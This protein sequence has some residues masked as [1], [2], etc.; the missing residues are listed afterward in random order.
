ME[1]Q[2][3]SKEK[4]RAHDWWAEFCQDSAVHGM[5]YLARRDLHWVERLFWLAMI[6]A[7][8]YYAISSCYSQWERFRNNPIVYE[9]EYLFALRNFTF[10]G[11]TFCTTYETE[12]QVAKLI[13]D[14]WAVDPTQDPAKAA[15]YKEFLY[16]LNRLRYNNLET[17]KPFEN[18]T[19]LSNLAYVDML[20]A[21]QEKV[22]PSPRPVL[23]APIITEVGLCQS[24]SQLTRYGNPYG[25]LETLNVTPVRQ[26]GFFNECQFMHKPFNSIQTHVF[27]YMH[28]VNE[29]M[30]P[31]DRRTITFDAKTKS[32]YVLKLL[33]SSISADREVRNLP[34]AY[35]KCRYHD[36]NNLRYYSPYHPS[37]CRLECR[38]NWA[39]SMCHCKPF[40]Y[41]A[42][43]QAPICNV[44]GM[45]CL[46]ESNWLER[47][48]HCF[49]LCRETTY[50]I[51]EEYEQS[52]GDQS[53]VGEQFERTIIIKLE[54]PKMGM[55]RRVVFSTD[56]LI[57]S[58]GGAIGLFLGASFMTFYGLIHLFLHFL[59][60]QCK[61]RPRIPQDRAPDGKRKWFTYR[62]P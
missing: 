25:R 17:L 4:C 5:P 57:M 21:L 8:A 16:V 11:L 45:L 54:L 46:A 22:L 2:E 58:F 34:V 32:S 12:E 47:P 28:D 55:K 15:Y 6:L 7:S 42:A 1:H 24:T 48:C 44:T 43:P 20:L 10:I 3:D 49:S 51:I 30:L 56:Q 31:H 35:R 60:V 33:I 26:C 39:L 18:D 9:Y 38:I 52:G 62:K 61:C 50:S 29:L 14:T 40:F 59:V 19:T 27:L 36:E 37:L 41:A 23:M 13:R 53:Y